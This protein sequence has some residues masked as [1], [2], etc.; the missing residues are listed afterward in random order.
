MTST[1]QL[2]N[3]QHKP[4]LSNIGWYEI[5]GL[6][7]LEQIVSCPARKD[8][9]LDLFLTIR[10]SLV[11]KCESLLRMNDHGIV[12]NIVYIDNNITAKINKPTQ[13]KIY[14]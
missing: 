10:P 7:N 3:G 13:R 9:V 11:N 4:L 14:L 5:P 2:Y 8:H 12:Y 6:Y 1:Y